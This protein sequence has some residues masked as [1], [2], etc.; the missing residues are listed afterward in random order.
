VQCSSGSVK[1]FLQF[2]VD[3]T[4]LNWE[5]FLPALAISYNTSYHST[6]TTTPF[7]LLFGEKARLSSFP[8]EDIQQIHYGEISAAE[9]SNLLQKLRSRAHQFTTEQGLKSKNNF[10]KNTVAHKFNIG[11]KVLISDDFYV[12]KNPQLAPN[13]TVPGEII[14]K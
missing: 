10:D 5:T 13:F 8:N 4:T 14:D 7:K 1:K 3:D 12:G 6:V 9:R 11:D 2:F